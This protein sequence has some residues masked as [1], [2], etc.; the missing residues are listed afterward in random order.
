MDPNDILTDRQISDTRIPKIIHYC[1]FGGAT[2]SDLIQKCISSWAKL[3]PEYRIV[4]WNEENWD[5]QKYPYAYEAHKAGKWAFVS[6]VARLDILYTYGGIYLDTDVELFS[7]DPFSGLLSRDAFF[8]F[9]NERAINT[10][11]C[12]GTRANNPLI[13]ALL[14]PYL[15]KTFNVHRIND[16]INTVI[17]KPVFREMLG[18]EWND[19]SQIVD[20]IEI[21][22]TGKFN[23]F[24]MHYGT[25][26]WDPEQAKYTLHRKKYKDTKLKRFLRN[27][28]Y[29]KFIET[30]F[31]EGKL[32]KIYTFIA[33]DLLECGPVYFAKRL[34]KKL[35]KKG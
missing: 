35:Q 14:Q 5:I 4:E 29:F 22:T 6:D 17:N 25:R 24:A 12:C 19:Q 11:M 7:Q 1:W 2:K 32:L 26:T 28:Q 34:L 23:S 16:E 13:R 8:T 30:K 33:Y 15:Q 18:I 27:P 20:N 10:G 31:G 9:E 3:C 21:I